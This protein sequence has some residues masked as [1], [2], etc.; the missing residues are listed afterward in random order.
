MIRH[1]E[2]LLCCVAFVIYPP[3]AFGQ[4]AEIPKD[5]IQVRIRLDKTV[6][7]VGE[8]ILFKV[9]VS[10]VGTQPFLIPNQLSGGLLQPS[11]SELDFEVRN[12][13]GLLVPGV[14]WAADCRDYKPT[15]LTFETILNDYL[16]LRPGTSFVQQSSLAG[17]D[18]DLKPG[19]YH[20][21]STYS[22]R[23]SPLGCQMWNAEDIE[24][25]PFQAWFGTTAV[26]DI[27]F[28]ILPIT[29]K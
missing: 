22:A 10:N 26:N 21:K 9:I 16:L 14:G 11:H 13:S 28:T 7:H 4:R 15:K 23:F 5:A 6:F 18:Y 27:S 19:K 25:F 8:A 17:L 3:L 12:Q 24:K 29:K 1:L 2:T 20:V